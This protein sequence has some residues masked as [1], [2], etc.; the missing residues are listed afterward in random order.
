MTK[1]N[2]M[3]L[4]DKPWT[5]CLQQKRTVELQQGHIYFMYMTMT[6]PYAHTKL[7]YYTPRIVAIMSGGEGPTDRRTLTQWPSERTSDELTRASPRVYIYIY[8][9]VYIGA[10]REGVC[11]RQQVAWCIPWSSTTWHRIATT[12]VITATERVELLYTVFL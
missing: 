5:E 8:T 9:W 3:A 10:L 7:F 11:N 12:A 1:H 6:A 4:R 2:T